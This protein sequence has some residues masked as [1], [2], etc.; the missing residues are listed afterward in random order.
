M[1]FSLSPFRTVKGSTRLSSHAGQAFEPLEDRRMLAAATLAS[2]TMRDSDWLLV[3][4]YTDPAGINVATLGDNDVTVT[5]P[6]SYSHAGHFLQ[7]VQD[8]PGSNA[9]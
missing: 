9:S 8:S 4:R 2:Q 7:V 1:P 5:G 3:V 6:N